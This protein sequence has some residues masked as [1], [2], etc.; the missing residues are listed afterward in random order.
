[1]YAP[2]SEM[3]SRDA[4]RLLIGSVL[5]RPIAW[6]STQSADG[7]PNVAPFSFFTAVTSHPPTLL[8]SPSHRDG[9]DKDT[10]ANIRAT[11]DFVVNVVTEDL[12]EAMNLTSEDLPR[13]RSEFEAAGVTPAPARLVKSPR[14]AES[15]ISMECRLV[16]LVDVGQGPSA[17]T[18]VIGEVL[19]WH[20]RDDMYDAERVHVR[21][22]RLNA[23]GRLAGDWYSKTRDQ[24]EMIRPNPNYQGR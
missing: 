19:A 7:V 2:T 21:F 15:P 17:S 6:V 24:F 10:L 16:Q 23:V 11:G 3:S 13:G 18:L 4:Y 20:I 8:F 12:A 9:V 22:D 5:P 1:M 14:V